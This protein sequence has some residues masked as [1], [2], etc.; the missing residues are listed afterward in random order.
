MILMIQWLGGMVSLTGVTSRLSVRLL[1]WPL[2][3]GPV[4]LGQ[5]DLE[6][7]EPLVAFLHGLWRRF[8]YTP[9]VFHGE[10]VGGVGGHDP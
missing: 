1:T 10:L 4:Q 5:S 7:G 3:A 6:Q 2:F 9:V 8:R